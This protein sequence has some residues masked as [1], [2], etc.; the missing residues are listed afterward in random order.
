[1]MIGSTFQVACVCVYVCMCI[2]VYMWSRATLIESI[3]NA[4]VLF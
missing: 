4:P 2:C 1:M 3:Y